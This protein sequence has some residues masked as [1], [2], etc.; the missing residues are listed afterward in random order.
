MA[1]FGRRKSA[2]MPAGEITAVGALSEHARAAGWE[3]PLA[4][5]GFH[6][7]TRDY[8]HQM[9][10]SLA[11]IHHDPALPEGGSGNSYTDAYRVASERGDAVVANLSF[12]VSHP[13]GGDR[14]LAGSVC[15]IP[16]GCVLPLVL[17]NPRTSD[18][19]MRAMTKSVKLDRVDFDRTFEVRSGH[20]EYAAAL[21][22]P[23]ADT[24]LR[25]N[26]WAFCLEFAL[27]ASIAP[28]PF[29]SI[30]EMMDRLATMQSLVSSIPVSVRE[31]YAVKVPPV[32]AGAAAELSTA[33]REHAKQLIDAMP[34]EQRR[35]LIARMRTEGPEAIIR[36]L[37]EQ[38][39]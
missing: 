5:P 30:E 27:L 12:T 4:D 2:A 8:L 11:G 23:M 26:D 10:E 33:D 21:L 34:P 37:L 9:L 16:L 13:H 19:Y 28:V 31:Q 7:A 14:L 18:P 39:P 6:Q 29:E 36:A 24:I 3:G 22:A 20:P 32:A 1:L 17:I 38:S 25:R 35:D 15:V